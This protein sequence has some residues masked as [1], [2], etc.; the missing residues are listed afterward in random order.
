MAVRGAPSARR[1]RLGT[2]LRKLR[3]RAGMSV[4]EAARMLG[5]VQAQIS[6][7]ESSRYGVSAERVR[8]LARNYSCTDQRLIEALVEMATEGK[9]GWWDQYRE[10]LPS[11]LLDLAELEYHAVH[12]RSAYTAHVPGLLQT[13]EHA[14]EVFRQVVPPLS[15]PEVEHRVS[16][17]VKRQ[18]V[19]YRSPPTPYDSIVHEAALRVQWGGAQG[20]RRQLQHLL[21]M[22]GHE[23]VTVR[24]IPFSAGAYPG[25]GQSVCYARGPVPE[26]D[27]VQLDQSHGPVFLHARAQLDKYRMLFEHMEAAALAPEKSRDFIRRLL[28]E[29]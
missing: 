27:T 19:L 28:R 2:E 15:P 5:T 11:G 23:H 24:V 8:T 21:E 29:E 3:E 7:M 4:T 10:I 12:L 22:S 13:A 1:V 16:H 20:M 9:T 25:S 17:R 14:R 6:N 18:E 26:L